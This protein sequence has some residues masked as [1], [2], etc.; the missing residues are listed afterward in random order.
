LF[1]Y[2]ISRRDLPQGIRDANLIHAAGESSPGNLP[3][4]TSAVSLTCPDEAALRLLAELLSASGVRHRAIVET[5]GPFAGQLMAVGV[6]PCSKKEVRR[7]L[8]ALPLSS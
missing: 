5:T 4:T 2:V 1:H 7:F 3:P 8:S 6:V